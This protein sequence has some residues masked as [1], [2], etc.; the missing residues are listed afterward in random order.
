MKVLWM[1]CSK[2]AGANYDS[3]L[4]PW[5]SLQILLR[6]VRSWLNGSYALP[7]STL[8]GAIAV[9]DLPG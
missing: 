3:L 5:E 6:M 7:A 2:K 8:L 4:A 9:A 1:R